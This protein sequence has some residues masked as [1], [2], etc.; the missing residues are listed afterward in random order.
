MRP[1]RWI[2]ISDIHCSIQ[3]PPV[4][5]YAIGALL[6]SLGRMREEAPFDAV[7][8]T[9]D[10]AQSGKA[11]EYRDK[12][13]EFLRQVM[14]HAG[15]DGS[16]VFAVPGNHDV[17]WGAIRPYH[18]M[19]F[20]TTLEASDEVFGDSR[21]LGLLQE[22]FAGFRLLSDEFPG[23]WRG[24]RYP[25]LVKTVR[26]ESTRIGII[27]LN[28]AWL[29]SGDRGEDA[30]RHKLLVGR[31]LLN[32]ALDELDRE[33]PDVTFVLMHHPYDW[34]MD[35]EAG[36]VQSLLLSRA[37]VVLTG[38][39]HAADFTVVSTRAQQASFLQAGCVFQDARHPKQFHI[40]AWDDAG[41]LSA[42][43]YIHAGDSVNTNWVLDHQRCDAPDQSVRTLGRTPRVK[44]ESEQMSGSV[45][46]IVL[47]GHSVCL[48][49]DEYGDPVGCVYLHA[50]SAILEKVF[51]VSY[52]CAG[53]RYDGCSWT[54][55]GRTDQFLQTMTFPPGQNVRVRAVLTFQDASQR[56]AGEISLG[57]AGAT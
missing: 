48:A 21:T 3:S 41:C 39:R 31:R 35:C 24:G 17:D 19:A 46:G 55:K 25:S 6:A 51:S 26:H 33:S 42:T 12:V 47:R 16:R 8:I 20:P 22:K 28:T 27:G 18:K 30:D 7:F 56:S 54:N 11:A 14:S 43:P 15:V 34:L 2:H 4:R 5:D 36:E 40:G 38:H 44:L 49:A 1:F 9:G 10:L 29:V 52:T 32:R 45:S 13:R 53:G 37:N 23:V 50:P 57:A